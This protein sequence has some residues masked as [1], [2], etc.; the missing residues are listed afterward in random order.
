[1]RYACCTSRFASSGDAASSD[2]ASSALMTSSGVSGC[3]VA[4]MSAPLATRGAACVSGS[5]CGYLRVQVAAR[6]AHLTRGRRALRIHPQRTRHDDAASTLTRVHQS[7]A[8]ERLSVQTREEQAGKRARTVHRGGSARDALCHGRRKRASDLLDSD[9]APVRL[10]EAPHGLAQNRSGAAKTRVRERSARG[11]CGAFGGEGPATCA[12]ARTRGR[13]QCTRGMDG[14]EG[15]AGKAAL[16]VAVGVC[17]GPTEAGTRGP[18]DSIPQ[19]WPLGSV[20]SLFFLRA[21]KGSFAQC[22]QELTSRHFASGHRRRLHCS[23]QQGA[24]GGETAVAGRDKGTLALYG[25]TQP[26]Q[27]GER[28]RGWKSA[29]WPRRVDTG[30]VWPS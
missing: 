11:P 7:S 23:R 26:R 16:T 12:R 13:L 3:P 6:A 17:G 4:L 2:C 22:M 15:V 10:R 21:R 20:Y 5:V 27:R 28:P 9:S 14:S 1:M 24:R 8:C 29:T 18:S 30:C 25:V 19:L